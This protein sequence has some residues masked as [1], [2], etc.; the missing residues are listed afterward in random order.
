MPVYNGKGPLVCG[1]Y[2]AIKLLEKPMK[3]LESVAKKR[4]DV[5]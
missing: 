4:S 5:R 2:I 1:S 3:V